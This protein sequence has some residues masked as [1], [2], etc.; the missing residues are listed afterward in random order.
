M[1]LRRFVSTS[2][3][4]ELDPTSC[5]ISYLKRVCRSNGPEF[6]PVHDVER[7]FFNVEGG[8]LDCFAQGRMGMSRAAEVFRAAAEFDHGSRFGNQFRRRVLQNMRA[9]NAVGLCF[10]DELDHSFNIFVRERAA[11]STKWKPANAVV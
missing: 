2:S 1:R 8:L 3:C 11:I 6:L 4:G 7:A 9:Q 10:D 5:G